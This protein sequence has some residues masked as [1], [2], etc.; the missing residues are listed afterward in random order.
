[1]TRR[2]S[3]QE[4]SNRE[5]DDLDEM[6]AEVEADPVARAAY[7]DA[8]WRRA[9]LTRLAAMRG[10]RRQREV[11][12]AMG[13]TQSAV[14]DLEQGR[15]D[16][17][18]STL[19]RY[20]RAIGTHVDVALVA[21]G[22]EPF[23]LTAPRVV[24]MA[25]K[26]A[27]DCGLSDV[28]RAFAGEPDSRAQS[29]GT[30]ADAT[31]L[32][33]PTVSYS[34]DRLE[35]LGWLAQDDR[36]ADDEPLFT[37][38]ERRGL[39]VGVTVRRDFVQASLTDLRG[40]A[41]TTKEYKL[42]DNSPAGVVRVVARAVRDLRK[43]EGE[44][45][46]L[47]G[48]GLALAGRVDGD[49]GRVVSAPA[50]QGSSSRWIEVQL[51]EMLERAIPCHAAVT[52]D[53]NALAMHAQTLEGG[54][55]D[56]YTVLITDDGISAGYV[57]GGMTATGHRGLAGQL[58][59]LTVEPAGRACGCGSSGCLETTAGVLA[60][61]A[62]VSDACGG[63]VGDLEQASYLVQEGNEAAQQIFQ[64]AG[65]ALGTLLAGIVPALGLL[66]VV[67]YGP[68]QLMDETDVPS[69]T[70]YLKGLRGAMSDGNASRNSV[71]V[72]SRRVANTLICE[73]AATTARRQ[74]L[75]EPLRWLPDLG[76]TVSRREA[77][78][79][80]LRASESRRPGT[81]RTAQGT[82]QLPSR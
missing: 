75:D 58:G 25:D 56:G 78:V 9:F 29:P 20:A 82:T 76:R 15:V 23:E 13:T 10:E 14:S 41:V 33:E 5:P 32:P 53:A 35:A 2:H 72:T 44:S 28:L 73:A 39:L 6:L 80:D 79:I 40:S 19:Q 36:A 55:R 12:T 38:R 70:A 45:G 57:V 43:R 77:R 59:H 18:L 22:R 49:S 34:M 81:P 68:A 52:N 64:R 50:L 54:R 27:E 46:D 17:R 48:L 4:P 67:L 1:M 47:V 30:V 26:V 60:L 61:V 63:A 31:G 7:E 74:F 11:A 65:A 42:P 3:T 71:R 69:A 16:P 66:E 37:L 24:P 51:K 8:A 21:H 62:D